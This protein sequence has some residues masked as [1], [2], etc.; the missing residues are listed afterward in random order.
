M[1]RHTKSGKR[2][3]AGNQS[4]GMNSQR[5]TRLHRRDMT[6]A[7]IEFFMLSVK[8]REG[9]QRSRHS[10]KTCTGVVAPRARRNVEIAG[11]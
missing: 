2:R 3:A 11:C 6:S 4:R 8:G 5:E 7:N 9:Q 10:S 1:K